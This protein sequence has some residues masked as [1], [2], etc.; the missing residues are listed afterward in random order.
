MATAAMIEDQIRTID[1]DEDRPGLDRLTE[2]GVDVDDAEIDRRTGALGPDDLATVIYTSGTTGRPKGCMLTHRNLCA[3]VAQTV[4]AI[5]K[6][7][8]AVVDR[9][10]S[11]CRHEFVVVLGRRAVHL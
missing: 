2:L 3:N 11:E 10:G 4:D 6:V 8:S 9:H 7:F 5:D 1:P